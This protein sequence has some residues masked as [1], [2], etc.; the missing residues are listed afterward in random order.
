MTGAQEKAELINQ[1]FTSVFTHENTSTLP[2]LVAS[3]F[4]T[5]VP[6]NINVND[7]EKLLS[8][9][10]GHKA[11]GPD[12][13]PA[14]LLKESA[15]N[16]APLL[17][18]IYKASLHQCRLPCDWKTALV[19]P[20]Y[21]K[22]AHKSLANYRPIC[23]TSIPCKILEHL[24]YSSDYTHLETN[25]ILFDAQHGFRKNRSCETQLI[26]TVN[27]LAS[28]LN[29]EEQVDVITLDFSKAFDKVP[30]AHLFCKLEFYGLWSTYLK[31][32]K[33]FLT[34]RKQ[35]VAIDNK[36]STHPQFFLVCHRALFW[37]LYFSNYS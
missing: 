25:C 8:G 31:W 12:G 18:H 37:A 20:I 26:I 36:F 6:D 11:H 34:D 32:I 21:K 17:T 3:S 24:I 7:V 29:L 27:K 2:D 15:H 23:L 10:Q 28:R 16:M 1:Q 19:F 5:I 33:E 22:G 4:P 35:Q 13:I 9:L 30:H 14:H